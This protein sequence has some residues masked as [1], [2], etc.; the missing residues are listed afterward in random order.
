MTPVKWIALKNAFVNGARSSQ[1][2]AEDESLG[3]LLN[4]SSPPS[5]TVTIGDQEIAIDLAVDTLAD[6]RDKINTAAPT[7]VTADVVASNQGG[8]DRFQLEISGTTTFC[9]FR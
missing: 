3:S 9:V 2:L 8:I 4:L 7:G 5:S 6:V 1:F